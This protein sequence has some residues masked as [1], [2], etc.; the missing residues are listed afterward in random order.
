MSVANRKHK[1]QY[2]VCIMRR[3]SNFFA[4]L[5]LHSDLLL[6]LPRYEG[7]KD[8]ELSSNYYREI[9]LCL[10]G[11]SY[12]LSIINPTAYGSGKKQEVK[13]LV[14]TEH[15]GLVLCERRFTWKDVARHMFRTRAQ[16]TSHMAR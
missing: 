8:F 11:C 7:E 4:F 10:H 9:I 1:Q 12:H 14:G 13:Q 15:S 2:Y 5:G 6:G 16:V 3:I